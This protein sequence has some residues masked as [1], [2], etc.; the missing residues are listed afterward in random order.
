MK[1]SIIGRVLTTLAIVPLVAQ[2]AI[3]QSSTQIALELAPAHAQRNSASASVFYE[4]THEVVVG[5]GVVMLASTS[6][7]AGALRTDD[8][9][10]LTVRHPDGVVRVFAHDFRDRAGAIRPL[11]PQDV[12]PL[13]VPGRNRITLTLRDLRRPVRSSSAYVLLYPSPAPTETATAT[14]LPTATTLPT[15]IPATALPTPRPVPT[16]LPTA[17]PAPT[18]LPTPLA[19]LVVP[20]HGN[21]PMWFIAA[22]VVLLAMVL[23]AVLLLRRRPAA[24]GPRLSGVIHL[25]DIDTGERLLNVDLTTFGERAAIQI[26]PLNVVKAKTT[27]SPMAWLMA[28]ATGLCVLEQP[29][30]APMSLAD[31]TEVWIAGRVSL[32]YRSSTLLR[33]TWPASALPSEEGTAA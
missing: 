25:S 26:A 33:D 8:A 19:T 13:F 2:M 18:A 23:A 12:S 29:G 21:E 7:G 16:A 20:Q 9:M 6:D 32:E 10:T 1:T 31:Q 30:E 14:A 5:V 28:T 27:V 3:A 4:S 15:A 24:S 22:G 17:P 11:A